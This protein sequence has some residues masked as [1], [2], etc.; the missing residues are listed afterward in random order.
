MT[1]EELSAQLRGVSEPD[2]TRR[3]GVVVLSL[4]AIAALTPVALYQM[5]LLKH[6]PEPPLPRLNA[7]EVDAAPEAYKLLSMPDAVLGIGSYAAT[8]AL[9]A[10]GGADRAHTQPWIPLLL[11]GKALVD[12]ANAGRLSWDQWAKHRAFCFWCM[13]AAVATWGSLPLVVPEARRAWRHL[14]D[15]RNGTPPWDRR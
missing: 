6:L 14:A 7:D 3:R 9:A 4:A 12:T 5:G 11:A 15:A 1:P 8:M 2:L 13:L 10:M